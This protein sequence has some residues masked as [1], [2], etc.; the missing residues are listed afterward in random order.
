MYLLFGN[1]IETVCRNFEF[2]R[3][4]IKPE[5]T[6][7]VY[8]GR[9]ILCT[10]ELRRERT[11]TKNGV[12]SFYFLSGTFVPIS[13]STIKSDAFEVISFSIKLKRV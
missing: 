8:L 7:H 11:S 13:N 6:Q 1:D 12:K 10:E 9:R 4:F 3:Y 5:Y 2:A